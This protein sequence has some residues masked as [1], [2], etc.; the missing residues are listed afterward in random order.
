MTK[1][2]D[3][4]KKYFYT[5]FCSC[6]NLNYAEAD[7]PV[8]QVSLSLDSEHIHFN[9]SNLHWRSRLEK[10]ILEWKQNETK[11]PKKPNYQIGYW[12]AQ[13]SARTS[14]GTR[15]NMQVKITI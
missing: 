12:E 15:K 8:N 5:C 9:F 10:P 4:L 2:K 3:F 13:P 7:G 1:D 14:E 6:W 11:P